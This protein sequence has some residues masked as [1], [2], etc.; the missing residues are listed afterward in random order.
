MLLDASGVKD[1]LWQSDGVAS[2][3]LVPLSALDEVLKTRSNSQKIGIE[4]PNTTKAIDLVPLFPQLELIAIVFPSFADGRGFS[5]AR[6][7]RNHGYKGVLRASGPLIADQAA[8]AWACGFDEI[9]LPESSAARQP[10]AQ[11]MKAE[12]SITLSYQRG[13]GARGNILDQR[14]AGRKG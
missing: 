4:I 1:N 3:V 9:L 10:I 2:H 5:L 7:L 13:Y 11:W 6:Q 12:E 14:R 8:D